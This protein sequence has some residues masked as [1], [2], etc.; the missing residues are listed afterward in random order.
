M[1][2]ELNTANLQLARGQVLRLDEAA[3]RTVCSTDGALWITEDNAP[4][5]D[6]VLEAGACHRLAGSALVQALSPATL[7]LA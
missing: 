7:S 6:V 5:K 1:R 3:G 2:I 4:R